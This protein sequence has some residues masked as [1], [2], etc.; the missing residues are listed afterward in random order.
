MSDAFVALQK[1]L[2]Q[3]ALSR[4]AGRLANTR[5]P[6]VSRWLIR[7]FAAHYAVNLA[8][9]EQPDLSAYASFNEFF[10]RALR[11]GA[12]PI[13]VAE[14]ALISP[15]DGVLS[16]CG[17]IQRESLLQAKGSA[18]TL[19]ALLT[20]ADL[21]R[22]FENGWF[23]TIYLAPADYHRVHAPFSGRLVRT[24]AVPGALFSVNARTEAGVQGL[25]CR[26]ERLVMEFQTPIGAAV[27]VMVGALIVASIETPFDGPASPYD[28]VIA[29]ALDE[30][31]TRGQEIGRF[32]LGSTVIVVLPDGKVEPLAQLTPG[33]TV[34]MGTTLGTL[35]RARR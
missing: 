19:T 24:I 11:P 20:R 30:S 15:A 8:E 3:H 23:A 7:R 33:S 10:T 9:A 6:A 18:Y 31:V 5:S 4:W 16:Q 2:P 29:T 1:L 34:R 28:Q 17:R 21:A 12:R 22:R 14:D 35:T 26:N 27:V 25:F 13:S 32:L